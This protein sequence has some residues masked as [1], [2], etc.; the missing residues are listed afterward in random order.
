MILVNW[1][2]FTRFGFIGVCFKFLILL[3]RSAAAFAAKHFI[4]IRHF[5]RISQV[6][7]DF[8]HHFSSAIDFNWAVAAELTDGSGKV[9]TLCFKWEGAVITPF[10]SFGVIAVKVGIF[11]GI[12]FFTPQVELK[13]WFD[14]FFEAWI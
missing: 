9:E 3:V 6:V 11:D 5:L 13:F 10:I 14:R 4:A 8:M 1:A 2:G 7:T 12:P